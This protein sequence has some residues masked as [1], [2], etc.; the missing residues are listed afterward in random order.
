[1]INLK[2]KPSKTY[3]NIKFEN[4]SSNIL[5]YFW[6]NHR[7]LKTEKFKLQPG[8]SQ[9]EKT[10]TSHPWIIYRQEEPISA[11]NPSSSLKENQRLVITTDSHMKTQVKK[12]S[13]SHECEDFLKK[14]LTK[15]PETRLG[16]YNKDEI[17]Q[18][19]F[20]NELDWNKVHNR[21][22]KAP[23]YEDE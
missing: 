6:I 18:H 12:L 19:P 9:H 8:E 2:S 20:F 23:F 21:E 5:T 14:V 13:V 3:I 16:A 15:D 22:L 17:K 4:K 11:Y 1:M 10:L 7:Q